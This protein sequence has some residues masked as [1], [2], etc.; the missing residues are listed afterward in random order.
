VMCQAWVMHYFPGM[1]LDQFE[2]GNWSVSGYVGMWDFV[3]GGN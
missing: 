2:R 1:T 3:K